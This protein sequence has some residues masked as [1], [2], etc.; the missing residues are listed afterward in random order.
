MRMPPRC[1]RMPRKSP[2]PERQGTGSPKTKPGLLGGVKRL[3]ARV[4]VQEQL[5][6]AMGAPKR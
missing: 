4:S 3:C 6:P 5:A 1:R 2:Q